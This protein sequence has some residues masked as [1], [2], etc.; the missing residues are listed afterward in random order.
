MA[1][2]DYFGNINGFCA[3]NR[4][5]PLKVETRLATEGDQSPQTLSY[6]R[7]RRLSQI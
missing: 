2:W 7:P 6:P 5:L 4:G 1:V 3:L